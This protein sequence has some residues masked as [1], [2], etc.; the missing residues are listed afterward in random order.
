[1]IKVK[2]QLK[3]A[4]HCRQNE[5]ITNNQKTFRTVN[6][7]AHFSIIKHPKAGIILIDTGYAEHFMTATE[8]FPYSI[9]ARVTPI[10]FKQT[11]SAKAQLK[12][13]GIR[14]EEV[15]FIIITHFHADHIAGLRDFPCATFICLAKAYHHVKEA[16]G[17]KALRKG[18]IPS[19]LP[20]NFTERVSFLEEGVLYKAEDTAIKWT[21]LYLLQDTIY[22]VFGDQ[23]IL[24]VELPGHARG[25][26][27]LLLQTE[28][29]AV[30]I[31][32]DAVW[33]SDSYRYQQFAQPIAGLILDNTSA[34][35]RTVKKL[36]A[37]HQKYPEVTLIP[38]HCREFERMDDS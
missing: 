5:K 13:Q 8:A 20:Q 2:H 12:E 23:S 11:D 33:D 28:E 10:S 7:P 14:A 38:L 6:F 15:R 31:V 26:I 24:A 19:L 17:I 9:Y 27:G 18:Y 36:S 34:Y 22:D 4:G 1:M 37:Y 29:E 32:A 21:G 16:S 3:T 25:Q 35:R 30:F